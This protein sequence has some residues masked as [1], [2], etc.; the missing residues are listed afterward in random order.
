M[1]KNSDNYYSNNKDGSLCSGYG[2][3]PDSTKCKGCSDCN[4]KPP[5]TIKQLTKVFYKN[6]A[7]IVVGKG[8]NLKKANLIKK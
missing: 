8:F 7:V 4:G 5:K 6:H 2:F 1:K 3:F